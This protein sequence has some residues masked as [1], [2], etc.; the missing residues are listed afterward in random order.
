TLVDDRAILVAVKPRPD[1]R[2]SNIVALDS[3]SAAATASIE[4]TVVNQGLVAANGTW[5]DR[6]WL[7]LDDK[8][9]S[10]DILVSSHENQTALG[11]LEEYTTSSN[12]FT[13]PKRFRGTVYVL[14]Q[15]D[16]GNAIDE[17]PNDT[18]QSNV[19]AHELYVD[20]IPFAD[21]VVDNV[22][23]SAQ[24]FE[25]NTVEVR[26]TVTNRGAGDSDLGAWTE[27]VWLT[28][29]KNRPHPGQGDKLLATLRYNGGV[30]VEGAGYDRQLEVT[31]PTGLTSGT[32]YI[33]P[34][35][36]PY[37]TL[38]EDSLATNVNPDDPNEINS[39]NYRARAISIVG[40]P[41]QPTARNIAVHSVAA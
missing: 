35:V 23:T 30:L 9:T 4:F 14:V 28:R 41:P 29:D 11:S 19:S 31:L 22:V 21:L 20:P 24:A 5:N 32:Y 17:W 7:S 39:S 6:V 16:T 40:T 1:L 36:D 13:V 27:Q 12:V 26:Y 18:L 8:L 25:G 37:G 33:M 10:D 15:T 34:W 2:V 3:V 38:L